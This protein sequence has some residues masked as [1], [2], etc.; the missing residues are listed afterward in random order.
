MRI[1]E[2]LFIIISSNSTKLAEEISADFLNVLF[3][4]KPDKSLI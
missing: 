4:A 2:N 3:R 1:A